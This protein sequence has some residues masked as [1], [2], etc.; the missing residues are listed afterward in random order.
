MHAG[1]PSSDGQGK[2][3][4][5]EKASDL[6]P[7]RTCIMTESKRRKPRAAGTLKAPEL[8]SAKERPARRIDNDFL[9]AAIER[10]HA[11]HMR[12]RDNM[13]EAYDDL[14]FLAGNQWPAYAKQQREAEER[15]ILTINRLPQ[16]VRQVTGD[17]RLMR[18]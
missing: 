11:A 4:N 12:E 3:R 18:P 2:L 16:F 13:E 10:A 1:R 15:P 6:I 9:R 17:I 5:D 7:P 14:E 8:P